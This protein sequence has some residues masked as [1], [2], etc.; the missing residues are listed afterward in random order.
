MI[1]CYAAPSI[2]DIFMSNTMFT[3][4]RIEPTKIIVDIANTNATFRYVAF[5]QL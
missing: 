4:E 2:S 1:F 3:A 5:C